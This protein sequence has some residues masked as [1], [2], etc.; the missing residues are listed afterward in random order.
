MNIIAWNCRGSACKGFAGLINDIKR[1]FSCAMMILVET[2]TS[3]K[4]AKKIAKRC[5]FDSPFIID[6]VGQSGGLW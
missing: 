2:H 3:E 6:V 1:D 5:G 4:L